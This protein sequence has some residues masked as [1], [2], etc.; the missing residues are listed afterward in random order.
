[1]DIDLPDAG[2]IETVAFSTAPVAVNTPPSITST[3]AGTEEPPEPL[4]E[5]PL[6]DM[7]TQLSLIHI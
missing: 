5:P 1:M 2:S 6:A 7:G 4:P 3:L